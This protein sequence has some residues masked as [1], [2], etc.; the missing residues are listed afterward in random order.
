M[1]DKFDERDSFWDLAKLVPK[2]K[3]SISSFAT[4][5]QVTDYTIP[6]SEKNPK[7]DTKLSFEKYTLKQW[8]LN[9]CIPQNPFIGKTDFWEPWR[10]F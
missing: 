5:S 4:K 2:K 7:K 6:G 9:S 1:Q 3:E 8:F 10:S